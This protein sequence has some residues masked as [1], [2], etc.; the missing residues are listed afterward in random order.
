MFL[1]SSNGSGFESVGAVGELAFGDGSQ[2]D[3]FE[4][5]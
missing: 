5:W 2:Q 1:F 3:G 4:Q